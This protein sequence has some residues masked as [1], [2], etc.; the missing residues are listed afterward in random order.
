[1]DAWI[2]ASMCAFCN[3]PKPFPTALG[4][5]ETQL[6]K[7][8][9][10]VFACVC[11]S[12]NFLCLCVCVRACVMLNFMDS[13]YFMCF[14]PEAMAAACWWQGGARYH[15]SR[16]NCKWTM[17]LLSSMGIYVRGGG[18]CL[19]TGQIRRFSCVF[20]LQGSI[21]GTVLRVGRLLTALVV[22]LKGLPLKGP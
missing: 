20:D 18:L 8:C 16:R 10:C 11:A 3:L 19:V 17:W 13:S 22:P 14:I 12:L 7:V 21:W 4:H 9:V 1:M 15:A 2:C 5:A 6:S